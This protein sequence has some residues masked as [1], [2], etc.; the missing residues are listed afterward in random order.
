M[1]PAPPGTR[2]PAPATLAHWWGRLRDIQVSG[3]ATVAMLVV[4][5]AVN[6]AL[7]PNFFDQYALTSNFATFVPLVAIAVGQTIVVLSGGIDLSLGAQVTLASVV[8]VQLTDGELGNLPLALTAGLGVGVACGLFNGLVVVVAR[9]QPIVATFAT[10][11]VFS[12]LALVVLP[13]PGGTMP[14]EFTSGYRD[15][16]LGVPVALLA[17]L[18]IAAGWLL[19]RRHRVTRHIYAVGGNA[20]AAFASLVP[21]ARTRITAYVIAGMFASV[22]AFAILANTGAGDPFIGNELTLTSVAA[23]VIGGTALRGG[24]GGA[25]GSILGAIILALVS[26]IVF[27]ADVPS[28]YRQLANGLVVILALALA[29]I[30]ALQKRRSA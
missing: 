20:E 14:S 16:V 25:I 23:V 6:V 7:Q 29:G 15:S 24:R 17:I 10:S 13:R 8:T 27:F 22:S 5:I 12:G 30:P 9:L 1:N 19:L 4:V 11:F 21:V 3:T 26:N 18:A 28:T 2:E